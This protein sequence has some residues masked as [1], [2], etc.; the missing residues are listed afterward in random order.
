MRKVLAIVVTF[1]RPLLLQECLDSLWKQREF[2]LEKIHVV[3]NSHDAATMDVVNSFAQ[4]HNGFLSYET[5]D[6]VGPAGGFYFGLKKFM[7]DDADF[8]W[9]MDDDIKVSDSSLKELLICAQQSDYVF[10]KVMKASGEQVI[11]YGWWAVLLSRKIV[12]EVGLPLKDLF[13]WIEDTEYLQHRIALVHGYRE[14]RCEKAVVEH[15]HQ[16]G[17]TFP[18]W[19]YYYTVRNTLDYRLYVQR[20]GLGRRLV[21]ILALYMSAWI[22][23]L[24]K[25]PG[26]LRKMRLVVLGT[27]DGLVRN[28]GKRIDPEIYY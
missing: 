10:P 24:F 9:L 8:A 13:Y 22:R 1:K 25:E 7:D 12:K 6:N 18:S 4:K 19:Y 26:K 17:Q 5:H 3:V 28:T 27:Y 2:G 20:K 15:H 11:S 14:L 16:R 21:R 23:I